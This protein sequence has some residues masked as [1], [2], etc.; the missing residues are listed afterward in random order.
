MTISRRNALTIT[1]AGAALVPSVALAQRGGRR[2]EEARTAPPLAADEFEARALAVLDDIDSNQRF[3]NVSRD[4]GR[5]LRVFAES[6]GAKRAL[7]IGTSTG[8]SGIW[9]A[10]GLRKNGGRITT[11]EIDRSRAAVAAENFKRAGVAEMIDI[12]I[13]NANIETKKVTG[14]LDLVFSDADKENYLLYW[15]TLAP[16]VRPG[17]LF[18]SDNMAIPQPEPEYIQAI[19]SDPKF[20]TV[21][22]N[23]QGTGV[24]VSYKKL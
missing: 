17:G 6:S 13:G 18:I 19:T 4:D 14:P 7:E 20:D 23:M 16:L 9:L 5:L 15:R 24:G 12:V 10:L 1:A 2:R 11:F 21:F 3:L 8:Y 22:L